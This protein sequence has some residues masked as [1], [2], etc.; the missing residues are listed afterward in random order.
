VDFTIPTSAGQI[1]ARRYTPDDAAATIFWIH[2]GGWV[3]WDLDTHDA[4]CRLLAASSGC[5]VI[6]VDYRRAPEHPFPLRS[7]T[8]GTRCGRWRPSTTT[9][10]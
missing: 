9:R 3:I 5:R 10:R 2:G 8:A 6:A 1:R 4:V 7:T